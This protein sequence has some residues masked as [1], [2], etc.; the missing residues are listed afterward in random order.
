MGK[1]RHT[2]VEEVKRRFNDMDGVL[3]P[4][5]DDERLDV[6]K[7]TDVADLEPVR[8]GKRGTGEY[9]AGPF[10]KRINLFGLADRPT[11]RLIDVDRQPR[12]D[13]RLRHRIM[14]L[15]IVAR[16]QN[17]IH[18]ADHVLHARHDVRYERCFCDML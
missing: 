13:E 7:V 10:L 16:K 18:L 15:G 2:P 9:L 14:V 6:A 8:I 11:E 12:F 5:L 3:L 1:D 4:V 17:G